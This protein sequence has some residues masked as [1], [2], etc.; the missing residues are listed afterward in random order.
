MRRAAA[1]TALLLLTGCGL[2][3]AHGV[4]EPGPVAAEQRQGGD[5]QVVPPAPR[6]DAA[7][8]EV[9]RGFFNA[10][11]SPGNA[12]AS[13]REFLGPELRARWRD[14]GPV[15]VVGPG[16]LEASVVDGASG[17]VHVKGTVVAVI[18]SDGAYTPLRAPLEFD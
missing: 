16:G 4:H 11:A 5:V 15:R 12:H 18:G 7:P 8:D 3:L 14:T 6:D 17:L 2:P 10:Q 9:V 13:A 1:L